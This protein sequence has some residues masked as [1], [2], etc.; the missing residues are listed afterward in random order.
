M[1]GKNKL[2]NKD[3]IKEK[4]TDGLECINLL[5]NTKTH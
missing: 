5:T 2:L 3:T 4:M 1:S